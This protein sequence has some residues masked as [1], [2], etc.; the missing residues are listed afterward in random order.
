MNSMHL[1]R[2]M[3]EEVLVS[4][5]FM[6]SLFPAANY[7]DSF[8]SELFVDEDSVQRAHSRTQCVNCGLEMFS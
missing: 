3:S 7:D 1:M 2:N 6:T 4:R 8:L 5:L